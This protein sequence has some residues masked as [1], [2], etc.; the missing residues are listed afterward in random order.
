[1]RVSVYSLLTFVLHA[2]HVVSRICEWLLNLKSVLDLKHEA[3]VWVKSLSK[4]N[5]FIN[6]KISRRVL[7]WSRAPDCHCVILLINFKL[8]GI[9]QKP[10]MY[11]KEFK[12]Y[13]QL[14]WIKLWWISN[15]CLHGYNQNATYSFSVILNKSNNINIYVRGNKK[16]KY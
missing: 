10:M 4:E 14:V 9:L 15:S 6:R 7:C 2:S 8:E 5:I 11:I 12:I 3:W 16:D 13:T 1:M